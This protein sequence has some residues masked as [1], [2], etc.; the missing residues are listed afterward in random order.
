[1]ADQKVADMTEETSPTKDDILY[2]VNSPM[3]TPADRKVKLGTVMKLAPHWVKRGDP[4]DYDFDE[5]DLT[6]DNN[7]YDLDLSSI[8]PSGATWVKLRVYIIGVGTSKEIDFRENGNSNTYATGG[9]I[10]QV[11]SIPI[12]GQVDIP[13]DF[14][15]VVEYKIS[16]TLSTVGIVVIGWYMDNIN[17]TTTTTTT[18][19]TS[20]TTSS[21]TTTTT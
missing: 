14:D 21:S 5:T 18:T 17:Y 7:W 16:S 13:L 9:V 1:M 6:H 8:V 11:A 12:E 15:R 4:S 19:S 20:T 10:T 2:E 3:G